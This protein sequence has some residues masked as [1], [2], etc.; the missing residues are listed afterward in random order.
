MSDGDLQTARDAVTFLLDRQQ[1]ADGSMPRNSLLNGRV[2]PDSFGSQLDE[3]AYPLIMAEQHH[4]RS[5]D[6]G[7]LGQKLRLSDEWNSRA[8]NRLFIHRRSYQRIKFVA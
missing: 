1:Q 6:P 7:K 2:A 5:L 8:D 4:R 3:A